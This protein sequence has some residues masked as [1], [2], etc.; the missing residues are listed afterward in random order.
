MNIQV[1]FLVIGGGLAGLT[2]ALH[3][4]PYGSVLVLMKKTNVESASDRAQGGIA[5]VTSSDDSFEDHEADTVRAGAGLCHPDVVRACIAAGPDSIQRLVDLGVPFSRQGNQGKFDLGKEGGHSRRRILHAGDFTGRE[6]MQALIKAT[7]AQRNIQVMENKLAIN[8]IIDHTSGSRPEGICRG[9]YAL[10]QA[11]RQI[12]TILGRCTVLATGGAGKVY[13]YTSNPDVATG[14]GMAMAYRAGAEMANLEFVQFHPTCLYHPQAKSFL[15]S[16]ALRGEGGKLRLA[17]GAEFLSEYD[18]RGSLATRDVVARAIDLELKKRGDDFVLLD[19]TGVPADY[20]MMRFP[21]LYTRCLELGMDMSRQPLPVVPAA[22]YFCGGVRTDLQGR[23][24]VPGLYAIG[25]TACTGFHGANRLASN[26]LLEAVV[27]GRV[28]AL[29]AGS[30]IKRAPRFPT[31]PPPWDIGNAVDSDESVVVTQNWDEIRQFTWNYVGIVRS[32]KRLAR[33]T[34][35]IAMVR[36]E[37][38]EYYWNFLLTSDLVELRN[39]AVVAEVAIACARLRQESRGLHYNL[40]HPQAEEQFLKDT[41]IRRGDRNVP[42]PCST[43]LPY[44]WS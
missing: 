18:Q 32:D 14:D 33:A 6:I 13:L 37:I 22:H 42:E 1:D 29:D 10:D 31:P 2:F 12:D 9:A 20:L 19:M 39:I 16:E 21:N 5:S 23:T 36:E 38:Q 34:R 41:V 17:N 30:W 7:L 11:T 28:A 3:A 35:R 27:F 40:D 25:E 4:A 24:S 43:A 15:L 8:L 26:S 44:A